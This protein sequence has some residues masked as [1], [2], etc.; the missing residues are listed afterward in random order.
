MSA[1]VESMIFVGET[2][3]HGLG[4]D[5]TADPPK[6]SEDIIRCAELGWEVDTLPMMTE[7]HDKV[8]NYNAIYRKDNNKV[9]GVVNTAT[10]V[11]V[12]NSDMFITI[13]NMI[14]RSMDVETAAS[15]GIGEKVFGCFKIREQYK[16]LDDDVDHYFVI[17]NDHTKADGK[18]TVINTPIR[19]VCQNTLSEA[20]NVNL[21]KL[22]VPITADKGVNMTLAQNLLNSVQTCIAKLKTKSEDLVS[23]KINDDYMNR[24]MDML[25]PFKVIDGKLDM[26]ESGM[27]A[28]EKVENVRNSFRQCLD[29]D[30]L[31][32]YRGT[33]W[34][35][36]NALTDFTQ[37]SYTKL[38]KM[39]DLN[40]RMKRLPGIAS[41]ESSKVVQFLKAADQLAA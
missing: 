3:W 40:Y 18:V 17:M 38:D 25:F 6:T 34:Q 16:L 31:G 5:L 9:L 29:A 26:T 2:P 27:K 14:D 12:Q 8:L 23:K 10:P 32:N 20:L 21:Y 30:N 4:K 36:F 1:N 24:L 15:L 7:I 41:M 13:E 39:Y 28:N 37:H 22:R 11:V 19:V 33:Q 35:I